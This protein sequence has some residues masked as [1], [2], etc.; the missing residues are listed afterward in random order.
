MTTYLQR[1]RAPA[2]PAGAHGLTLIELLMVTG[3]LAVL[4]GI[5]IPAISGASEAT[6]AM[7][8]RQ[9]L[10]SSYQAALDG[11]VTANARATLCPSS[12]GRSCVEGDDWSGGWIAFVDT[13]ADR[14]HQFDEPIL[15]RQPALPGKL[16][17][18]STVG[19]TRI[20]IQA[21]GSV[22][23]SNVTFTLCDGRG[24]AKAESLVLSNKN[25][26]AVET[27]TAQAAASTCQH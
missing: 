13:N 22:Q 19:R 8:A 4:F 23:G 9:Q 17:L 24:A 7:R 27:P 1:N 5:A 26:L 21:D 3:G 18:H 14:E 25:I 2:T 10:M 15:S 6:H 16:R 20:E 11:A 12:D